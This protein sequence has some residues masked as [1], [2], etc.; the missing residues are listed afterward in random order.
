MEEIKQSV[1]TDEKWLLFVLEQLLSNA[2][3]YTRE[4]SISIYMK[5]KGILRR[6][7]PFFV[8]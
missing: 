1:V 8:S 2:L 4:G 7:I 5:E 3:K 6:R